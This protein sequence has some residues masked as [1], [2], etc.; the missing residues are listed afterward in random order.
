MPSMR[1][2]LDIIHILWYHL[3]IWGVLG[4]SHEGETKKM[5]VLVAAKALE[6]FEALQRIEDVE[7]EEALFTGQVYDAIS[8]SQLV[9]IDYEDLVEHPYDVR[10]IRELLAESNMRTY[11]SEEFLLDPAKC[12]REAEIQPGG[13]TRLPE[14]YTMGFVSYSGGTGKTTL[15]MDAALH[16]ARQTEKQRKA[17]LP[18]MLVELIYG[19]SALSSILGLEMPHLY[20]LAT[21]TDLEP[22]RF[23]GVTIIPM[24]YAYCKVLSIDLLRKYLK[25]EMARHVLTIVDSY[26]PHGLIGAVKED[27]DRWFVVATPRLDAIE[28]ARKLQEELGAGAGIILNMMDSIT[29]NLALAGMERD[30]DLPRLDRVDRFE[31]KLGKQ[32][33]ARAY[34]PAWQEFEKRAG[35]FRWPWQR[36]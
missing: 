9:I 24:D 16:F 6:I 30:L 36:K 17:S 1:A 34:G 7:Y 15:A 2:P 12:V 21:K 10:M 19:E 27:V 5:K 13:M 29:D 8:S 23:K 32:I 11:S 31:G 33:L 28:N 25:R 4:S 26:W 18:V 35:G 3:P 20:D 14:K 22:M